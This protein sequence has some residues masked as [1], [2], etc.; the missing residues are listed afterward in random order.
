[1]LFK[2]DELWDLLGFAINILLLSVMHAKN[3]WVNYV[4]LRPYNITT[5]YGG[6]NISL[7]LVIVSRSS[8]FCQHSGLAW[9][10]IP[11]IFSGFDYRPF[12]I[13]WC[14]HLD[15]LDRSSVNEIERYE[16]W[17]I[18]WKHSVKY[19]YQYQMEGVIIILMINSFIW[20]IFC[21]FF[22]FSQ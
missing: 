4:I 11:F 16:C 15:I 9:Y 1:M 14:S 8:S 17:Y 22:Y 21:R 18:W 7:I 5:M 10:C 2:L 6:C 20:S 3:N 13:N 19:S 12:I